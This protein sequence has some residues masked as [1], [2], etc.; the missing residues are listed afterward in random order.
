MNYIFQEEIAAILSE[1]C[2]VL[3][4]GDDRDLVRTYKTFF[5][6]VAELRFSAS[7]G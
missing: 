2:T 5:P 7:E 6:P 4:A 1:V 3:P